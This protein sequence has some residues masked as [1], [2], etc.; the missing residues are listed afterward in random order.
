MI[1]FSSKSISAAAVLKAPIR[2]ARL[3][4]PRRK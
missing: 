2:P 3:T 4:D 1:A